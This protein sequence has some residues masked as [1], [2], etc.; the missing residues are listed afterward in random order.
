MLHHT[1]RF[2]SRISHQRTKWQH[3]SSPQTPL[4]WIQLTFSITLGRNKKLR[5]GAFVMQLTLSRT[6]WK[7]WKVFYKM[8]SRNVFNTPAVAGRSVYLHKGTIWRKYSLNVC[9]ALYFSK[10]K[11]F[12]EHFKAVTYCVAMF[13]SYVLQLCSAVMFCNYV[14]QLCSAVMFCNYVLQ[15]CSHIIFRSYNPHLYSVVICR[16]I[17]QLYYTVM[18]CSHILQLCAAVYS[19]VIFCSCILLLYYAVIYCTDILKWCRNWV[20]IWSTTHLHI[21]HSTWNPNSSVLEPDVLQH[22]DTSV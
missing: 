16:Y 12:R 21:R 20:F 3:W 15:L 10:M 7:S 4:I 9:N 22:D 17:L 18:F 6:R 13:C 14:L 2:W 1:G 11:I 8:A 19:V 5:E